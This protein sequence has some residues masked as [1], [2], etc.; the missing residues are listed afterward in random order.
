LPDTLVADSL[1]ERMVRSGSKSA[2][3]G[4]EIHHTPLAFLIG[5]FESEEAA[6]ERRGEL[7]QLDIP[8]YIVRL[9]NPEGER[10]RL[11]GGAYSGRGDADVMQQLL[12]NAGVQDSLVTRV[13]STTS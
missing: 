8:T 3:F 12:R 1:T 5:E 4:N 7:E 11:Y 9:A 13:G 2:R 6:R 10:Y